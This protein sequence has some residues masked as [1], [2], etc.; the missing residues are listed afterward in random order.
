MIFISHYLLKNFSSYTEVNIQTYS[1]VIGLLIYASTYLYLLFNHYDYISLFNKFLIY[2]VGVDLLL[3][4]FMSKKTSSYETLEH[5]DEHF[6]SKSDSDKLSNYSDTDYSLDNSDLSSEFEKE[7]SEAEVAEEDVEIEVE[8][9]VEGDIEKV[10]EE[11][12]EEAE[13]EVEEEVQ[14]V[15]EDTN[16]KDDSQQD[17]GILINNLDKPASSNLEEFLN[18]NMSLNNKKQLKKKNKNVLNFQ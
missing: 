5:C 1:I 3:S 14:E 6:S 2:V 15:Q 18:E 8:E 13:A 10:Q 4:T 12:Q 9:E 17:T 11:V 7:S 16:K